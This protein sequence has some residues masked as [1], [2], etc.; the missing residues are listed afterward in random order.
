MYK[1]FKTLLQKYHKGTA[2]SAEEAVVNR[3]FDALQT[4]GLTAE[5]VKR[6]RQLYARLQHKVASKRTTSFF[7]TSLFRYTSLAASIVGVAVLYFFLT[8]SPEVQQ[9][10]QEAKKGERLVFYLSDSTLVYLNS[11]SSLHYPNQFT[12]DSREVIL[13][14]EAYFDVYRKEDQPFIVHSPN[15][16]TTVLGTT[17]NIS[18]FPNETTLVSVHEGKVR[19]RASAQQEVILTENEQAKWD[20]LTKSL[21]KVE[22]DLEH[23]NQWIT[24]RI[25]FNNT[26]IAEVIQVLNRRFDSTIEWDTSAR[27]LPSYTINGDFKGTDIEEVLQGLYFLYNIQYKKVGEKQYKLQLTN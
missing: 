2:T 23:S 22:V 13:E 24:G 27:A 11:N 26:S 10:V 9:L 6:N 18:D 21:S 7:T 5:E 20:K 17:F 25:Q 4:G 3:F 16:S 15:L 1:K 14:G 19:V 8:S 12:S